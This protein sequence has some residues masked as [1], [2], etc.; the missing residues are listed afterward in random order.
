VL[1]V[2]I[3]LPGLRCYKHPIFNLSKIP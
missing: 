3:C 1:I 2:S